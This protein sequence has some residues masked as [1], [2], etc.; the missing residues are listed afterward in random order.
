MSLDLALFHFA[1]RTYA[2]TDVFRHELLAAFKA[3]AEL[4]LTRAI[5][6]WFKFGAL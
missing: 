6:F 3:V 2:L 1:L 4:R 5:R